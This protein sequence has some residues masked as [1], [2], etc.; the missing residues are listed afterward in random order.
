[1]CSAGPNGKRTAIA[2]S[3]WIACPRAIEARGRRAH[4]DRSDPTRLVAR[5][6]LQAAALAGDLI[7]RP[8]GSGQQGIGRAAQGR[9]GHGRGTA[10]PAGVEAA[11][12][13]KASAAIEKKKIRRAEGAVG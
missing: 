7:G 9:Y 12:I 13:G 11:A 4:P 1:M 6:P 2:T 3:T 5:L 8:R 10:R